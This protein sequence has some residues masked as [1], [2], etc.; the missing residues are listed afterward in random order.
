VTRVALL[1]NNA[2]TTDS[3]SWKLATSLAAAGCEVTVVARPV[4]GLPAR[5]TRDG[6]TIVRIAQPTTLAW[7]PVPGL[8]AAGEFGTAP[9][10]LRDRLRDTVG[11]AAQG[12]RYVLRTRAWGDAI[13]LELAPG[14]A[15]PAA[16]KV[17]EP[18]EPGDPGEPGEPGEPA[19]AEP[20]PAAPPPFDIWQA[21]GLVTLPVALRLRERLGGRVVYDSRDISLESGRYVRLPSVWRRLLARRERAWARAADAVVTVNRPYAEHLQHAFGREPTIV[22]NGPLP[23]DPPDPPE[24]RFHDLLDLPPGDRVA[25]MVGAVVAHRGIEAA[26]EAIGSVPDTALV[27]I[28]DGEAKAGIEAEVRTLPHGRRIHFL[29][30]LPPDELPAWTAAADVAVMPIQ[31]STLNHRLTTPT[32]LFDAMGAGVPVVASD[33]PGMAEIVRETGVGVLVDPSSPDAIAAGINEIL[34][35]P[36][37]RRAEYRARCLAEARGHYAWSRGVATLLQLYEEVGAAR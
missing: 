1:L 14:V 9:V 30:G 15:A 33:L 12:A 23:F 11:R 13:A 37:E 6:Y 26:C 19:P 17:T 34:D 35:A 10:G 31:P 28:G 4:A 32:R 25:L 29:A 24:R 20:A 27:I 36:P 7:L 3:R 21:E 5:E 2:F 8:P 22:Y 18:G 16:A